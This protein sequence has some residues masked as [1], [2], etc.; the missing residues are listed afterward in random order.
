MTAAPAAP[1]AP[2]AGAPTGAAIPAAQ[3][4]PA[5]SGAPAAQPAAPPERVAINM[6]Y[7]GRGVAGLA[8]YLA[9]E[10][11]LYAKHGVD[12][13]S[14][15]IGNAATLVAAV[16]GGEAPVA[17]NA[18]EPTV[19]AAAG[20]AEVVIIGSNLN[21]LAIS[22]IAQPSIRTPQELRGKRMGVTGHASP[23]HTGAVLYL[24]SLGL[25]P[26]RDVP[27]VPIGGMPE[28]RGALESGALEVATISPPLSYALAR[29][30][31][32]ELADL[33]KLDLKY[34]QGAIVTTRGY[35]RQQPDIVR[36]IM[37]AYAESY[38]VILTDKA[39]A[40]R[41][42]GK[43]V[44]VSDP[45]ELDLTYELAVRGFRGGPEVNLEAIQT[46]MDLLAETEA[47]IRGLRA[48]QLVDNTIASEVARQYGFPR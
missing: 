35:L 33:S 44:E 32:T 41:V 37:A 23:T 20:G 1:P 15:N 10:D 22:V 27:V 47:A 13:T 26:Q 19:H 17:S 46:I 40:Q 5:G 7:A 8:H 12:V 39:A 4:A 45:T 29:A 24:R 34:Q 42:L 2:V 48:E 38:Q 9:V 21:G 18:V 16:V 28:I 25:D 30:G 43:W 31:F 6:P 3:P 14:P 36:R 11:G